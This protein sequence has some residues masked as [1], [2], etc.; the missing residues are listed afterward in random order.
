M[1]I[2]DYIL[3]GLFSWPGL[4]FNEYTIYML[5]R[6]HRP[7][8]I[9]DLVTKSSLGRHRVVRA[10][11]ILGK[12]G[13]LNLIKQGRTIRPVG[14]VPTVLQEKMIAELK[15]RLSMAQFK[16][17]FL[18]KSALDLWVDSDNFVDNAR[19]PFLINPLTDEPLEID[20]YYPE[21][22]VGIEYNGA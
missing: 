22:R 15:T 2:P 21:D 6:Y 8:S 18:L 4:G 3:D 12:A 14:A 17:E 5:V 1:R 11:R 13:W 9:D 16:G 10:C 19:P 20:R 7:A